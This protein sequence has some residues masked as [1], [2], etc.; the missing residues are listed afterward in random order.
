MNRLPNLA[1]LDHE[2]RRVRR[3]DEQVRVRLNEDASLAL[4]RFAQIVACGHGFF[5][6]RFEVGGGGDADAIRAGSAEVGQAVGLRGPE[7]IHCLGKHQGERIF[8]RAA[9]AGQDHRV[10]EPAGAHALAQV[11]HGGRVPQEIPE[12]HETRVAAVG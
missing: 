2:L 1:E 3:N 4:I 6:Q 7:A 9:G 11:R 12:P 8:S 5:H 10:R